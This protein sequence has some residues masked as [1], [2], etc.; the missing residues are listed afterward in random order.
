MSFFGTSVKTINNI[1]FK[2]ARGKLPF[3]FICDPSLNVW[4]HLIAQ[5]G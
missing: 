4:N 2:A 3:N 5:K 1:F